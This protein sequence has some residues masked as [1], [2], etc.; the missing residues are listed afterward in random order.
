[1]F[2]FKKIIERY[3]R[4]SE[5]PANDDIAELIYN[6]EYTFNKSKG[7]FQITYH[8]E[9]TKIAPSTREFLKPEGI[10]EQNRTGS[11]NWSGDLHQTY[12]VR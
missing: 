6:L 5:K 10:V 1:M 2:N 4:N 9:S 3:D 8:R 7:K 12:Q 11:W